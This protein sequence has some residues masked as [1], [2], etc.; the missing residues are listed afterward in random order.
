MIYLTEVE[1]WIFTRCICTKMQ[2]IVQF[3]L[4][5][6]NTFMSEP[7]PSLLYYRYQLRGI[8]GLF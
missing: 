2:H 1:Q 7:Q 6:T 4:L 3:K 8:W 5:M